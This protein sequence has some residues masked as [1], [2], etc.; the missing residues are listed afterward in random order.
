M[1]LITYAES[2]LDTAPIEAASLPACRGCWGG[3][4]E[5]KKFQRQGDRITGAHLNAD[6]MSTSTIDKNGVISIFFEAVNSKETVS[7]PGRKTLI[8]PAGRNPMVM[9]IAWQDAG[10]KATQYEARQ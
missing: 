10:W 1:D 7:R 2:T 3:I 5:L 4:N 8:H 6:A 9:T